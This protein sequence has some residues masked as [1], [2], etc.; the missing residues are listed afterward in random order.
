VNVKPTNTTQEVDQITL[1][2]GRQL[3]PPESARKEKE[4]KMALK[5]LATLEN[6]REKNGKE[7]LSSGLNSKGVIKE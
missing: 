4:E 2:S 7:A 6:A 1:W 5:E 3:Q